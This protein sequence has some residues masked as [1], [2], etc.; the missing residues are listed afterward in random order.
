MQNLSIYMQ[1]D[2]YEAL[3]F[4]G[5][6]G[7]ELD[8]Q[9]IEVHDIYYIYLIIMLICCKMVLCSV[10]WQVYVDHWLLALF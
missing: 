4:L 10:F 9:N 7:T 3:L 2:V 1:V 8:I 5:N 6:S